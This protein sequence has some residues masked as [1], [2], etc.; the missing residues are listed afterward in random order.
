MS[1][2]G[3]SWIRRA[4]CTKG[5][6]HF[7][8]IF[9]FYF[10]FYF[11]YFHIGI[12]HQCDS[13]PVSLNRFPYF[14]DM[15]GCLCGCVSVSRGSREKKVVRCGTA[16]RA[17]GD[18]LSHSLR[19]CSYSNTVYHS[20]HPLCGSLTNITIHTNIATTSFSLLLLIILL[21]YPMN[22][23]QSYESFSFSPFPLPLCCVVFSPAPHRPALAFCL[24]SCSAPSSLLLHTVRSTVPSNRGLARL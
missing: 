11:P 5:T 14:V 4:Q 7:H 22:L 6:F 8:S 21:C 13:T 10:Y 3:G 1:L 24:G 12:L 17:K 16:D 23:I 9:H 15:F 19:T 18:E 2:D 20:I